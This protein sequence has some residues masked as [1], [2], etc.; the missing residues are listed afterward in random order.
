MYTL[1]EIKK[2][3]STERSP[4]ILSESDALITYSSGSKLVFHG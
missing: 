3:A 2:E 4:K 1:S